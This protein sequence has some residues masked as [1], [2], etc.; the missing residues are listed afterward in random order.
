MKTH[1]KESIHPIAFSQHFF[2]WEWEQRFFVFNLQLEQESDFYK[3][4]QHKLDI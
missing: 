3:L 4:L 2:T 1:E